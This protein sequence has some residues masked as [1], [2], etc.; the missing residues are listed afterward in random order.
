MGRA[1]KRFRTHVSDQEFMQAMKY[2]WIKLFG[3]EPTDQQLL[4]IKAHNSLETGGRRSMWNYNIGNITTDG[5]VD[6]F[7]DL[8]TKEQI[9][10]GV[11]KVMNLK[12]KAYPSLEAGALDYLK[13]ISGKRYSGAWQHILNP[14]AQAFS[15]ALKQSHYYTAD[16]GAYTKALLRH[17]NKS[18]KDMN[19]PAVSS[20]PTNDDNK[21]DYSKIFTVMKNNPTEKQQVAQQVSQQVPSNDV[22][23][24]INKFLSSFKAANLYNTYTVKIATN[25]ISNSYEFAR[26]LSYVVEDELQGQTFVCANDS[27]VE[28]SCKIPGN[29][30]TSY[31]SLNLIANAVCESFAKAT[32]KI[33]S[34][35][36]EISITANE[37][38]L[39]PINL[40]TAEIQRRKFLIK[41]M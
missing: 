26:I 23:A 7:D 28:L 41:F 38:E 20:L 8:P 22:N 13:F 32:V 29:F 37:S 33:G 40:V 21:I 14:D 15:K 36:P 39:N 6:Y 3:T 34:I 17:Y 4:L 1:V 19:L 27:Q 9:K 16:E 11:W 10:P 2:A 30:K 5:S 35:T 31:N 24:I 12:Y 25:E 18:L